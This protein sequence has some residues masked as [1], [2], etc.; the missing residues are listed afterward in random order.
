MSGSIVSSSL[1]DAH[2][3]TPS[4]SL[5]NLMAGCVSPMWLTQSL[6]SSVA[7]DSG[8]DIEKLCTLLGTGHGKD[9]KYGPYVPALM[10]PEGYGFSF[11]QT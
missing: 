9:E 10:R 11:G 8:V 4:Q 1:K 7:T 3:L 2:E 5:K 6:M